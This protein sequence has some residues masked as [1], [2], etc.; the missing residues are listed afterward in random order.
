[1]EFALVD[2]AFFMVVEELNRILDGDHV[3]ALSFV[4]AVEHGGECRGFSRAAGP[5]DEDNSIAQIRNLGEVCNMACRS[6]SREP[7]GLRAA[8]PEAAGAVLPTP[9]PRAGKVLSESSNLGKGNGRAGCR[10]CFN[11]RRVC[12]V[13]LELQGQ[14]LK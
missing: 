7:L 5:G 1:M 14:G 11:S 2:G 3:V 10:V 13:G 6:A 9:L 12:G 4:D 8:V